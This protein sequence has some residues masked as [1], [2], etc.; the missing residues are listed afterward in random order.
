MEEWLPFYLWLMKIMKPYLF[1]H[2]EIIVPIICVQFS[3]LC[4]EL[5]SFNRPPQ[6]MFLLEVLFPFLSK[7]TATLL[8]YWL[9]AQSLGQSMWRKP[10]V[11][12]PHET[13]RE[14]NELQQL[15]PSLEGTLDDP[16]QLVHLQ[17]LWFLNR[18]KTLS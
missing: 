15:I 9:G 13:G 17:F 18:N 5:T 7:V 8:Q 2:Q 12:S 3:H 14:L 6:Q 4:I 10:P 11:E 16:T 1:Q